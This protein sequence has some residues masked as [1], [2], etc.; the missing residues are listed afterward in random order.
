MRK[1][2]GIVC[3]AL[4]LGYLI[5]G[6][7]PLNFHACNRALYA[8][9]GNGLHFE[10]LAI[11]TGGDISFGS[12]FSI[13][14]AVSADAEA[15]GNI[16]SLFSIYD[17]ALPE[18]IY[19]AQWKN[20]FLV[21]LAFTDSKGRR[22]YREI[23]IENALPVGKRRLIAIVSGT[24]GTSLYLE[25]QLVKTYPRV[26]LRPGSLHGKLVL[27]DS[28]NNGAAFTGTIFG[29]A[30][31][32]RALD[33]PEV[34]RHH[35]LWKIGRAEDLAT[36]PGL[37]GLYLFD[38]IQG[39]SVK[40]L[41]PFARTLLIPQYHRIMYPRVLLWEGWTNIPDIVINILGFVPF[42]F[43]CFIWRYNYNN[44]GGCFSAI[45]A[46]LF[47]SASISAVI[48]LTQVFL[49]TRSSSMRD[50]ICNILGC[51][52]GIILAIKTPQITRIN[53]KQ[54]LC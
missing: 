44:E 40:D 32:D 42:G 10:P 9:D 16:R 33:P 7:W 52:I 21:R 54:N 20:E 29:L 11:V 34:G 48:E 41:S 23:G 51:A 13:E 46:V 50:L 5:F 12:A 1:H 45:I 15:I 3:I 39:S 27:G 30:L 4:C 26:V 35:S 49:P 18:N 8:R 19:A 17:G 53:T 31:F 2:A 14:M 25:G 43:F 24:G 28:S 6:L 38:R 36:E 47:A 22:R 37:A